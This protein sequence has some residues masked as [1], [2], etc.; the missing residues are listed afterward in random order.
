MTHTV[1]A[2]FRVRA[3]LQA[4]LSLHLDRHWHIISQR[5]FS[6]GP[7]PIRLIRHDA[8]GDVMLELFD[9]REGGLNDALQD[10]AVREVW[11]AIDQ[12]CEP[13]G[14]APQSEFPAIERV[15][16]NGTV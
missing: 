15:R 4:E 16:L 7:E 1:L 9:W 13:R 10:P 6:T 12:C 2:T 5:G 3:G 8:D 11:M 14:G